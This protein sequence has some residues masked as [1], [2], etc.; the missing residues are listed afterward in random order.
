MWDF[1]VLNQTVGT[2]GLLEWLIKFYERAEER[3]PEPTPQPSSKLTQLRPT[4]QQ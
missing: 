3:T 2:F 4:Y 1:F